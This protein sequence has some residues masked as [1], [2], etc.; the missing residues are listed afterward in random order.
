MM[1]VHQKTEETYHAYKKLILRKCNCEE[2][3]A[4]VRQPVQ[5]ILETWEGR[6]A[7]AQ[8]MIRAVHEKPSKKKGD[9]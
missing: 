1:A 3:Y 8:T 9:A 2:S 5:R 7:L 6:S 4:A